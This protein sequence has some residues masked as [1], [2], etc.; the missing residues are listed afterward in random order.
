MKK[1]TI[2]IKENPKDE[3]GMTYILVGRG[4]QIIGDTIEFTKNLV[5]VYDGHALVGHIS[6]RYFTIVDKSKK[7]KEG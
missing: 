7:S 1:P 4:I 6:K 2:I 3:S 5:K